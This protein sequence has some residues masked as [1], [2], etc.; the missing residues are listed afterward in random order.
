MGG[1]STSASPAPE[2][3]W[4]LLEQTGTGAL[5]IRFTPE[6]ERAGLYPA[7]GLA[8]T[9]EVA[10]DCPLTETKLSRLEICED[11]LVVY[12]RLTI[13]ERPDARGSATGT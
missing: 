11:C 5:H 8:G 4:D 1:S 12:T 3:R 13:T 6:G 9:Y 7:C 2:G 10:Q